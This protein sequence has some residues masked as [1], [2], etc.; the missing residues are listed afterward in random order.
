MNLY[1]NLALTFLLIIIGNIEISAQVINVEKS[2]KKLKPGFQGELG[3]NLMLTKNTRQIFEIGNASQLQY[4]RNRHTT[5]LLNNI[6]LMRVEGEDL[7]NNGF[8]HIR[9]NYT[10]GNGF[11]TWEA[12]TQH[13]YNSIR[14]L[15]RRIL[16]GSGPRFRVYETE[17]F[18]FF[19]APLV[20][21]E[22][23]LLND[24]NNTRTDKFKGDLI[25]SSTYTLDERI[26]FSH[27]TY[28]QPD[29]AKISD[30]RVF[31]ETA[32]EM[33]FNTSFAFIFSFNLSYDSEPPMDIPGLFYTLKNGIK[34][35]F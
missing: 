17:N 16:F 27:T 19:I 31:S 15:Q 7:I 13:Q 25:V 4:N 8:Q 24:D 22:Q 1:Y 35:N 6:N 9:Y 30:Y 34:Y 3:L 18:G 2:R 28:Y 12:F 21:F 26:K 11:T 20:M 32:L 10:I 5:L 33:K 23:E 29:F 14:L